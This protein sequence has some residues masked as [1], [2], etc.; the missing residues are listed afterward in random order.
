[1]PSPLL[2]NLNWTEAEFELAL[3]GAKLRNTDIF[4][5]SFGV[6]KRGLEPGR[7]PSSLPS[8]WGK[9]GSSRAQLGGP[10]RGGQELGMG[11]LGC[12]AGAG[13]TVPQESLAE[14][15][16]PASL[17]SLCTLRW[18]PSFPGLLYAG[19]TVLGYAPECGGY[20]ADTALTSWCTSNKGTLPCWTELQ[21]IAHFYTH[22]H[23]GLLK[24]PSEDGETE[25]VAEL[26]L[27]SETSSAILTTLRYLWVLSHSCWVRARP[28][29]RVLATFSHS[30]PSQ[31]PLPPPFFSSVFHSLSLLCAPSHQ[32]RCPQAAL[33]SLGASA[34]LGGLEPLGQNV[35]NHKH[36]R[37]PGACI[38]PICR[39]WFGHW[40]H[41]Y[42]G[43]QWGKE[44]GTA[45]GQK[46]GDELPRQLHQS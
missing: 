26:R 10:C 13:R 21:F 14:K 12:G 5:F 22:Y 3:Q 32:Q 45:L 31:L 20:G 16:H 18:P 23:L 8:A 38:D 30:C 9:L 6:T 43:K 2:L 17:L 41:P 37:P 44:L 33:S 19:G 24:H 27:A 1:M 40:P 11:A 25:I 34:R 29:R 35:H 39:S 36:A 15:I 4:H 42:Q 7:R 46:P 28:T